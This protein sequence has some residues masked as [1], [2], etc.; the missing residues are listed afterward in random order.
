[1][2]G[3][4]PHDGSSIMTVKMAFL[5]SVLAPGAHQLCAAQLPD[6]AI[7]EGQGGIP[8]CDVAVRGHHPPSHTLI[9]AGRLAGGASLDTSFPT[10]PVLH[11]CCTIAH[12]TT[13]GE[14][15]H[16]QPCRRA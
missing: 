9:C 11:S 16:R 3:Q 10:L 7:G 12:C 2:S 5:L 8:R 4:L 14:R 6:G 15:S 13:R 1:M